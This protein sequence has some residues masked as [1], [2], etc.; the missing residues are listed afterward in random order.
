VAGVAAAHGGSVAVTRSSLGGARFE[1]R[2]PVVAS[3]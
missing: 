1:F 3:E 2:L